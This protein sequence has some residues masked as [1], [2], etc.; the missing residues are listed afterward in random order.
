MVDD[1]WIDDMWMNDKMDDNEKM[2]EMM[3]ESKCGLVKLAS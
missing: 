3:N 1:L 2:I